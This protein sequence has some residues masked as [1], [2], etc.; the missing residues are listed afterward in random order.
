VA[1]ALATDLRRAGYRGRL[2]LDAIAAGDLY[3]PGK[4]LAGATLVFTD[5]PAA[6]QL[7]ATSPASAARRTWFRDYLAEHGTYHAQASWAADAVGVITDA[8]RRAGRTT[9]AGQPVDRG[10]LRDQIEST[11]RLDGLT[12]LIRYTADQHSGLHPESL[13]RLVAGGGRWHLVG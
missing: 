12:G 8:A 9:P 11:R 10:A 3:Q 13:T 5:T 1:G 6:D 4:A 7:I 2:H